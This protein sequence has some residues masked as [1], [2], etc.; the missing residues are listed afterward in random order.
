MDQRVENLSLGV[1]LLNQCDRS[2]EHPEQTGN[3]LVVRPRP[4]GWSPKGRGIG[5]G[6]LFGPDPV[7]NQEGYFPRLSCMMVL[8]F[9]QFSK[10]ECLGPVPPTLFSPPIRR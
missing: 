6:R 5:V 3:R 8:S 10:N 4:S 9:V 7:G 1:C 2:Q